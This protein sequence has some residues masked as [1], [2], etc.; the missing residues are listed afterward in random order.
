MR[1]QRVVVVMLLGLA[2]GCGHYMNPTGPTPTGAAAAGVS[3]ATITGSVASTGALSNVRVSVAN[4]SLSTS[5]DAY[6]RFVLRS[7]PAGDVQLVFSGTGVSASLPIQ[8][9]QNSETI[10]IAVTLTSGT[11]S[12]DNESRETTMQSSVEGPI[13][14]L[15][16]TVAAN[17]FVVAGRTVT[18]NASTVFDRS[19]SALTFAALTVG[20]RVEVTGTITGSVLL[21]ARV[22]IEAA[23]APDDVSISGILTAQTGTS[24]VLTLTVGASTVHTSASTTVQRGASTSSLSALAV[25]Q[26][27]EVE[28]TRRADG[29]IDALSIHIED[30]A[31]FEASVTG[32]LTSRIGTAPALTLVV[33]GVTVRTT[34]STQLK[35]GGGGDGE[36]SNSGSSTTL[37]FSSLVV[38]VTLEVEGAQQ[39]DGSIAASK[40]TLEN[41]A[42]TQFEATA[43]MSAPS[44]TCPGITFV[45]GGVTI[46]ANASTE[47]DQA[48][49]SFTAGTLVE[50]RGVRQL[51]GTV[52][53]DRIRKR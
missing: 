22:E 31:E 2:V 46:V 34:A 50:V 14:S 25:G 15:P 48:C 40:I 8:G 52:T 1:I 3:G 17:S 26:S 32:V 21:A 38:G 41:T 42:D 23:Q 12:V 47:F 7:V 44:G 16:P 45:L 36:S 4:T 13:A 11:A 19:G 51:N 53:A 35:A 24:P 30:A 18:T 43:T 27:L 33:G 37:D 5:V 20:T 28:G 49:S 6:N 9:V 39:A 29:S 10:N